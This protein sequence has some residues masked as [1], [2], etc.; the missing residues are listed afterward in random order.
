MIWYR[1]TA[2]DFSLFFLVGEHLGLQRFDLVERHADEIHVTAG[3]CAVA[4]RLVVAP[5]LVG[6]FRLSH[7]VEHRAVD[8]ISVH[9]PHTIAF[10]S[11][12]PFCGETCSVRNNEPAGRSNADGFT[13]RLI[14]WCR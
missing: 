3:V 12:I 4:K 9:G 8:G 7:E 10:H 6:A 14:C 13:N 1:P 5:A 11:W 2:D